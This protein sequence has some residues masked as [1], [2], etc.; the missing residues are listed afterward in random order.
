MRVRRASLRAGSFSLL[1]QVAIDPSSQATVPGV[2][3]GRHPCL[4]LSRRRAA[5]TLTSTVARASRARDFASALRGLPTAH[6][7]AVG[8]LGSIHRAA[9]AG[10]FCAR[11]PWSRG[12]LEKLSAAFLAAEARRLDARTRGRLAGRSA[13]VRPTTRP[14]ALASARRSAPLCSSGP[15]SAPANPGRRSRTHEAGCLVG[16]A[17]GVS[18]SLVSFCDSGHPALRPFGAGF[19]VRAAPAAQWTSKRK[20]PARRD[21]GRTAHGRES[22]F[23]TTD[24]TT[25]TPSPPNPPLEGEG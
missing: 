22:V 2:P 20:K 23:A 7:C 18:F 12:N 24:T 10:L 21:A 6:P 17:V 14:P 8:K 25:T 1:A 19:A 11:S 5:S 15:P 3:H 9:P 13:I 4:P 16:G